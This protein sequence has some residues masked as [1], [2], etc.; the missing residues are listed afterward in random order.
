MSSPHHGLAQF[1]ARPSVILFTLSQVT[2]LSTSL[3]ST[4]DM[5]APLTV[6]RAAYVFAYLLTILHPYFLFKAILLGFFY[7]DATLL[8]HGSIRVF[9]WCCCYALHQQVF[10]QFVFIYILAVWHGQFIIILVVS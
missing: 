4:F 3:T 8:L 5:L 2:M 7:K 9:F 10:G 6:L 1:V